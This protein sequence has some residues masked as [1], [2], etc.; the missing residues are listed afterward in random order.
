M[1]TVQTF[2]SRISALKNRNLSDADF[3]HQLSAVMAQ[4]CRA[5]ERW[6]LLIDDNGIEVLSENDDDLRRFHEVAASDKDFN[7]TIDWALEGQQVRMLTLEPVRN[8]ATQ[9]DAAQGSG[10]PPES[11]AAAAEVGD[12]FFVPVASP[13]RANILICL[14][15]HDLDADK[16]ALD[17]LTQQLMILSAL[18]ELRIGAAITKSIQT[19]AE[20]RQQADRKKHNA[21]QEAL[22]LGTAVSVSLE[23][24]KSAFVLANE[25]QN[26]LGVDRVTVIEQLGAKSKILAISGQVALNRRA[27]VV[28]YAEHLAKVVLK[29]KEALWFAGDQEMLARP[30]QKAVDGYL[31]E[32]LVQSFALIPIQQS[33]PPV[34]PSDEQSLI[35]LVNPGRTEDKQIRGAILIE[36]IQNPIE[37]E[38]VAQRWEQVCPLVSRQF[39]N[40]KTYSDLFLLPLML[41]LS[42][43]TALFR[44]HTKRTAW[45]LTLGAMILIAAGFLIPADFKV[46]CEGYLQPKKMHHVFVRKDGVVTTV[47]VK[48]GQMVHSGTA[49]QSRA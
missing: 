30:V 20:L 46:R 27:N 5:D 28:R 13:F 48:E 42:R 44:G 6:L 7:D 18:G 39:S 31:S 8:L 29:S 35:E 4:A 21:L 32:S 11:F 15:C 47:L 2:E 33:T 25:L 38:T 14:H 10:S 19:A 37:Q 9:V 23:K 24:E 26:Y 3:Y 49:Q 1:T 36:S 40:S 43:F 22:E 41:M 12:I 45:G 34:Y 17:Q 16:V